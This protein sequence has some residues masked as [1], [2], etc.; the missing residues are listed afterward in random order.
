M[1]LCVCDNLLI[2]VLNIKGE[3]QADGSDVRCYSE[4]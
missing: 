2:A 1:C 3:A 4:V